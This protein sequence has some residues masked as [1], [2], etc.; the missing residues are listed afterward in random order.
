MVY[1]ANEIPQDPD[2]NVPENAPPEEWPAE[3]AIEFKDVF[4]SYRPG[5]PTVLNGLSV[6]IRGGE[7][8]GIVGR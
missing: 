2:Y 4:M 5:L 1:Y 3:G 8:I 6:N 7:K